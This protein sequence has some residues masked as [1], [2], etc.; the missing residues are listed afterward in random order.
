MIGL[1]LKRY[2]GTPYIKHNLV[3][4]YVWVAKVQGPS[5]VFAKSNGKELFQNY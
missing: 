3:E 2:N 5:M 1:L 4:A